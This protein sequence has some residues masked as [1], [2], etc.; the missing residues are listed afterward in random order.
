NRK[1]QTPSWHEHLQIR[2]SKHRV[3]WD[4]CCTPG[5]CRNWSHY[6]RPP[7][8]RHLPSGYPN[9]DRK[10]CS[11]YRVRHPCQRI[12]DWAH[13][14][15]FHSSPAQF[16]PNHVLRYSFFEGWAVAFLKS[17]YVDSLDLLSMD[18]PPA[19]WQ[20]SAIWSKLLPPLR[21]HLY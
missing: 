2:P 11:K 9:Q 7:D 10:G 18:F 17:K 1:G 20:P 13:K 8:I 14:P 16:L 21:P 5:P 3:P 12:P 19:I 15:L 4:R 6:I